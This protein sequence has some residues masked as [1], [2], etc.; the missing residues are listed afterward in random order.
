[1]VKVE[2]QEDIKILTK[3]INTIDRERNGKLEHRGKN[4]KL[5]QLNVKCWIKKEKL[6]TVMEQLKKRKVAKSAKI[7]WYKYGIVQ[8]SENR[9]FQIDQKRVYLEFNRNDFKLGGVPYT[10]KTRMIWSD[11]E[12]LINNLVGM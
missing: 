1:M 6:L 3:D 4:K 5:K 9:R 11:T 10:E 2:K 8:F 12:V 7:E